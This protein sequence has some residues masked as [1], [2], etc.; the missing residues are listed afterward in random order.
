MNKLLTILLTS[1]FAVTLSMGAMAADTAKPMGQA[2]AVA[3]STAPADAKA[4]AKVVHKSH[5][6]HEGQKAK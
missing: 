5:K 3:T 2:A 1:L 6:K 4:P